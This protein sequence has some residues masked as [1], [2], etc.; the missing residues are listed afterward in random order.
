MSTLKEPQSIMIG[1]QLALRAQ[2]LPRVRNI[3][4]RRLP[5]VSRI[6]VTCMLNRSRSASSP[7]LLQQPTRMTARSTNNVG[8]ALF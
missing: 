8:H 5:R 3:D 2:I 4:D 6:G 1:E 7:V